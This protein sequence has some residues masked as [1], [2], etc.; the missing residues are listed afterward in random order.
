MTLDLLAQ[1][2]FFA[3]SVC[4]GLGTAINLCRTLGWL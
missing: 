2:F 3:G 4:L 1:L